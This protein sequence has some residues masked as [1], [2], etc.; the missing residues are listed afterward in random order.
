MLKSWAVPKGP[1]TKPGDRRLAVY[2]PVRER[3]IPNR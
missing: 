3:L 1:S 2:A